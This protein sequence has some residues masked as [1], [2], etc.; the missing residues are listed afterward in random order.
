[1]CLGATAAA[2]AAA[3]KGGARRGHGSHGQRLAASKRLQSYPQ[4]DV[5]VSH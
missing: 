2:P 3:S 4:V 5:S 1:M